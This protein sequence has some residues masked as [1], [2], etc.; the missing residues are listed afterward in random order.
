MAWPAYWLRYAWW[1]LGR[2]LRLR[3][4]LSPWVAF[5]LE[6][7]LDDLP[8]PRGPRWRRLLGRP[9]PS[10]RDLAAQLRAVAAERRVKGVVLHLRPVSMT[11]AQADALAGLVREVRASGKRVV[12]WAG[13]GYTAATYRLACAADEALIQ[14]GAGLAPLGLSRTY[15]FLADALGRFGVSGDFVQVSP[16]KT[17]ADTL[18]RSESSAEGREMAAWLADAAFADTVAAISLGRDLEPATAR[19][20][21][22]ATPC[23]DLEAVEMGA[24]DGIISEE[25]LPAR[26]GAEVRHWHQVRRAVLRP[27]PVRPGRVV[28]VI[29]VEGTIVDG[30]NR[31]PPV[32]PPLPVPLLL[33]PQCGDLSVVAQARRLAADRRVAAVV[34]WI[35]SRG[36]S[37]T[38]SE[39]MA[40]ALQALAKRKPL[41]AVMG[42]VAASGGYYVATPARRIL[43]QSGTL[44]GSIGVLSGKMVAGGLMDLLLIRRES[45]GRGQGAE[46]FGPDKPFTEVERERLRAMIGRSYDL[47]L[48]RV[49]AARGRSRTEIEAMAGGRVWTG[50]QALER[51]L[52]DEIGGFDRGLELA[53]ELG[54]L[55][56]LAPFRMAPEGGAPAPPR[57]VLSPAAGL[58]AHAL[59]TLAAINRAGAWYL[60]PWLD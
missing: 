30:R 2:L 39:A 38:A 20:L 28:G 23:T 12:C 32:A 46:M 15:A 26:L 17:A 40:S 11:A 60:C 29:R 24:V 43:A 10:F 34:L 51:G 19:R 31:R 56:P 18:T 16:Y 35:D 41:V 9:A 3:R 6:S 45:V 22:D 47:F 53:R 36:G 33:D 44:T 54:G 1:W 37:A 58:A 14:P 59:T 5:L 7:P 52:V 48:E 13:A 27:A 4:R 21:V 42:S 49:A 50:R 55:P 8:A 25:D 57:D